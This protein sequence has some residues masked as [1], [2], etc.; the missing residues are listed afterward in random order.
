MYFDRDVN[1]LRDFFRRRFGYESELSPTFDDVTRVD[2]LDAQ[3]SAS[4]VTKTMEKDILREL[5]V[6]EESSEDEET[7]EVEPEVAN[8]IENELEDEIEDLRKEL[9]DNL[10][11]IVSHRVEEK[12]AVNSDNEECDASHDDLT[13]FDL[14]H[15]SGRF[16]GA[17][18]TASTIPPDEVK[19]R[20][21]QSLA[22]QNRAELRKRAKAKGEA[23][24]TTRKR[25]E[26]RETIVTS[27]SAFWDG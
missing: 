26:N 6:D 21:K 14:P 7:E 22:K 13:S 20:V 17:S 4:G 25:R 24:A 9:Q 3:I 8:E 2:A 16:G 10:S 18:T 23:N 5:G 12:S 27:T 19:R 1:C 15:N 11:S